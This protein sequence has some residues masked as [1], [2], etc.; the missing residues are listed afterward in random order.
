MFFT[1]IDV[2]K[3]SFVRYKYLKYISLYVMNVYN[4]S[5]IRYE[6]LKYIS[7]YVYKC[8]KDIF[9]TL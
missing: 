3:M 2:S 5:L 4:V 9:C 7:L 1:F 8:L 6:C